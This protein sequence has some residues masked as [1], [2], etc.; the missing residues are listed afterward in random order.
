MLPSVCPG[1]Q[2]EHILWGV[3]RRPL[4][5]SPGPRMHLQDPVNVPSGPLRYPHLSRQDPLGSGPAA[6][7]LLRT[8]QVPAGWPCS[9]GLVHAGWPTSNEHSSSEP[10]RHHAEALKASPLVPLST[11]SFWR[12]PPA[13]P[14]LPHSCFSSNHK[15]LQPE[16]SAPVHA[17]STSS[18]EPS[19]QL[20]LFRGSHWFLTLNPIAWPSNP[21]AAQ[22]RPFLGADNKALST[23]SPLL[24]PPPPQGWVCTVSSWVPAPQPG[25]LPSVLHTAQGT[26]LMQSK[27]NA[28]SAP[29]RAWPCHRSRLP[30]WVYKALPT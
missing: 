25:S 3:E 23:A 10:T 12:V 24:G 7:S 2:K 19:L 26:N 21:G 27:S 1:A 30:W 6:L 20:A 17:I 22:A 4:G 28:V 16:C 18:C 13:A 14:A 29:S 15:P 5:G 9:L 8:H 11:C